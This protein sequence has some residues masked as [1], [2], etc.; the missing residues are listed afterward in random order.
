MCSVSGSNKVVLDFCQL[1]SQPNPK[2]VKQLVAELRVTPDNLRAVINCKNRNAVLLEFASAAVAANIATKQLTHQGNN[3]PVYLD[4]DAIEVQVHDIN[5]QVCN[6]AIAKALSPYGE[7][8]DIA[9]DRWKHFFPG[10]LNGIRLVKF[11]SLTKPIPKYLTISNSLATIIYKGQK[12][13]WRLTGKKKKTNKQNENQ[14]NKN[15]N[16]SCYNNN[17]EKHQEEKKEEQ[18]NERD[19]QP[20]E[21]TNKNTNNNN[22]SNNLQKQYETPNYQQE[23]PEA[24]M[25][26]DD[27]DQDNN[28]N[29]DSD[30]DEEGFKL[31]QCQRK[32]RSKIDRKHKRQHSE[33]SENKAKIPGHLRAALLCKRWKE[34]DRTHKEAVD[35]ISKIHADRMKSMYTRKNSGNA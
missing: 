29:D 12:A 18:P 33:E 19:E 26:Q 3:I 32:S 27:S 24:D 9:A 20:E 4:D 1:I 10:L 23:Q 7:V 13:A 16:N 15:Q 34:A 35:D 25:D 5:T 21:H 31:V 6:D 14:R 11:R 2:V 28:T 8:L 17:Q 30:P 22:K